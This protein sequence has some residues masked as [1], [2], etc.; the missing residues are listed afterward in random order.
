MI[1]QSSSDDEIP[2]VEQLELGITE[3]LWRYISYSYSEKALKR[4]TNRLL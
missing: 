4:P 2:T 1:R 3:D